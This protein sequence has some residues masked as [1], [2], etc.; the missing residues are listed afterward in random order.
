MHTTR[1]QTFPLARRARGIDVPVVPGILPVQNF[2][3]T[4]AFAA[5]CGASVPITEL[6]QRCMGLDAVLMGLGLPDDNIHAPNERFAL[7]Q[8]WRGSTAAAALLG[9]LRD[10]L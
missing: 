6:I 4:K 3:Q 7:D 10:L 5:R 9:N 2:K 8:L 1:T